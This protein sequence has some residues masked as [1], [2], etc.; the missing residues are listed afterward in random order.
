MLGPS[1]VVSRQ[2]VH[3][4]TRHGESPVVVLL[5]SHCATVTLELLSSEILLDTGGFTRLGYGSPG[6]P[7]T[8]AR[9]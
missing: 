1:P 2:D 6:V 4:T 8:R 3:N 9:V 7:L 5:V